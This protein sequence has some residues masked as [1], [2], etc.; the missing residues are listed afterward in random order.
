MSGGGITADEPFSMK[1]T[2]TIQIR[3]NVVRIP[4]ITIVA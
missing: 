2:D 3:G 1:D 4:P